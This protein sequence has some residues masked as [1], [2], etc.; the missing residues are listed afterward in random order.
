MRSLLIALSLS[1]AACGGNSNNDD[2]PDSECSDGVD[3]DGDGLIDFPDDLGCVGATDDTEN[4]PTSPKCDD[5]RDNDGDGKADYPS[6]PGCFAPAG[7]AEEDDCPD[8]Q[9]CPQ[10]GN[11]QDD[12]MNGAVDYPEDQGCESAADTSEFLNNP[13]ACG[14]MMKIKQLP[15]TGMDTGTLDSTSTSGVGSP[16]GGGNGAPAIAYVF[17]LSQPK[18]IQ[19]STDDSATT[20]DTVLDI[21]SANCTAPDSE[22]ACS[23]D[24]DGNNSASTVTKSLEAGTYYLIVSGHDST[25][26]GNYTL[27][28]QLFNGE[29]AECANQSDCGPGLLCRTPAGTTTQICAQPACNDGIDDEPDGL[30]DYPNDPG[31]TSPNDNDEFDTCPNMPQC[32]ECFDGLDNDGDGM[33]DFPNDTTCKAAG[34]ASESCLSAEGVEPIIQ[35]ITTGTT[36]GATNDFNPTCDSST[37]AAPDKHFRL[38]LPAMTSLT[39][40]TTGFD[41][42]QA[43]LDESCTGTA[44]TC[45]DPELFTTGALAAGSYYL[46]VDG[47]FSTSQGAYTINVSGNI[48]NG[49]PCDSNPL[50]LSG[51][52]SCSPGFACKGA[53]VGS[54]TCQT[55]QCNDGIDQG[56]PG[57]DFPADPGCTSLSD[58]SETDV[59]PG[60]NCPVC[61][62]G[63]DNDGDM[64]TD[65]P[66][67]P[68]CVAASGTSETCVQ[69]EGTTLITAGATTGDTANATDNIRVGCASSTSTG[70]DLAYE[71]K[72]PT[73]QSLTVGVTSTFDAVWS[74][75]PAS[76]Q[77][78]NLTGACGDFGPFTLTDVAAGTYFVIVDGYSTGSGPFTLNVSGVIAN[79]ARCDSPLAVAGALTCG[80]A[81]SCQG[82][83]GNKT[84]Q[85]GQCADGMDNN[86]D[87]KTDFPEDPGCANPGDAED[88]VCPGVNCPVCADGIDNDTDGTMD[89][90]FGGGDF[91]CSSASAMSEGFCAGEPDFGVVIS[92]FETLG[93]FAGAADNYDQT[94]QS[95]TGV[96]RAFA[97]Q[98]PVPVASLV[99]DTNDSAATDTV[100]SLKDA[101]C[102]TNLGCDDDG[103]D[104]GFQSKMTVTNVAAG[105][106]AIQVDAYSSNSGD[107]FKLHVKGTV[108]PQT[109]CTSPLF[110]AGVLA[111]PAGTTCTGNKCQ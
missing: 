78:P 53:V 17:N 80:T 84:C 102:G 27:Y 44:V 2:F 48:A 65:F 106:Y 60:V 51:A 55:A 83:A 49:E 46:V 81:F 33:F 82:P 34:D 54:K 59:C 87:G 11:G 7:D 61:A 47:Y 18:V 36:V 8:G 14:P 50:L 64:L 76:C 74:V 67:D 92:T 69:T 96:D 35:A 90:A 75:L 19:A 103:G 70:K 101:T 32:P 3:N 91:G 99:I 68:S 111:C 28:V 109:A 93:T 20:A 10:C 89:F 39:I 6:D 45:S 108:A 58:D 57:M 107:A 22:L 97:L 12:D 31:C 24:I 71:L 52:L 77:N 26:T 23:D 79:G 66:N 16:C 42:A 56:D 4:S 1:V 43:L 105:N 104:P 15:Q 37:G 40:N 73:L 62:D 88:T 9:F 85:A 29:G 41:V 21:R 98:L 72:V 63:Q 38:D 94:C 110:A 30:T 5:G 100:V 95:S 13:V 86:G 25:A